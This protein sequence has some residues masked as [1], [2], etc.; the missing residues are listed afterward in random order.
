MSFIFAK[1]DENHVSVSWDKAVPYP[2]SISIPEKT[3]INGKEFIVSEIAA[4][5]FLRYYNAITIPQTITKIGHQGFD[6]CSWSVFPKL[7]DSLE[8]IGAWS[9]ASGRF[10]NLT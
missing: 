9:F 7:P 6:L 2:K 10:K 5:G 1:I 8:Y 3:T 4:Q